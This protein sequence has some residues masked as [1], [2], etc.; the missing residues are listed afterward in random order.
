MVDAPLRLEVPP[1]VGGVDWGWKNPTAFVWEHIDGDDCLWITGGRYRAQTSLSDHS[2]AIPEHVEWWCDPADPE[3][4]VELSRAGHT[5]RSCVHLPMRGASGEKRSPKMSRIA[6]VSDRMETG[7]LRIIR[8]PGTTALIRELG[9]YQY[10]PS[11][12][13]EEPIEQKQSQLRCAFGTSSSATVGQIADTPPRNVSAVLVAEREEEQRWARFTRRSKC[14]GMGVDLR[15]KLHLRSD[16]IARVVV[17]PASE[18]AVW[19]RAKR[20]GDATLI[21]LTSRTV[22]DAGSSTMGPGRYAR[23]S[24]GRSRNATRRPSGISVSGMILVRGTRWRCGDEFKGNLSTC[25]QQRILHPAHPQAGSTT[26]V[27]PAR[28]RRGC[29]RGRPGVWSED[30]ALLVGFALGKGCTIDE[31]ARAAG[32]GPSTLYRKLSDGQFGDA[33]FEKLAQLA[34]GIIPK[35][36]T[37]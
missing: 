4:R 5:I 34:A 7:R 22:A 16:R 25:P 26:N 17:S 33:R 27:P 36:S 3:S 24:N 31:A 14:S 18:P 30:T 21:R 11:K 13:S 32:I 20:S 9:M 23:P 6:A 28:R 29:K 2:D 15:W 35:N 37:S 19:S 10:D 12:E 8:C 1:T